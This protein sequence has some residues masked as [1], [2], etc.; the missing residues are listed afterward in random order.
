[1]D[2]PKAPQAKYARI[3]QVILKFYLFIYFFV[4]N[5]IKIEPQIIFAGD[6][7]GGNMVVALC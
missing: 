5:V 6:S 4:K 2:Y 1:M 7:A 3:F